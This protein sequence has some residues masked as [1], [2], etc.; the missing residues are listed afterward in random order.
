ML[1]FLSLKNKY[2]TLNFFSKYKNI[3]FALEKNKKMKC[4][5]LLFLVYTNPTPN[6]PVTYFQEAILV[7]P[8]FEKMVQHSA[9]LQLDAQ[10]DYRYPYND[11]DKGRR[12]KIEWD[13]RVDSSAQPKDVLEE[14]K[15]SI[16]AN[17]QLDLTMQTMSFD[18]PIEIK[19]V[20]EE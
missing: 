16:K 14:L 20:T 5:L 4:S 9:H 8:L 18:E 13:I 11:G 2:I 15:E 7:G 1:F 17:E 19:V 10:V 12:W 6:K 3:I